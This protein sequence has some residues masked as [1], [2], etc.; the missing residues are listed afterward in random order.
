MAIEYRIDSRL[1]F[2]EA[3]SEVPAMV[4]KNSFAVL[5]EIKTSEILKSKG[6]DYTE[7]R[8]Y[9]ICNAGFASRALA[10]D[11]RLE[12]VLPCHLIVKKASD[13]SEI[14]VQLPGEIFHTLG[15]N[16]SNDVEAFLDE[17]ETKL[18]GIVNSFGDLI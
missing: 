16:S 6:F 2:E 8:T 3:C 12:S 11:A 18:K 1:T 5:A 4:K 9:D 7:L 14:S 17:V 10:I 15:S 13:H